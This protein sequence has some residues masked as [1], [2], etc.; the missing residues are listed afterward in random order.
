MAALNIKN[1]KGINMNT[2][3]ITVAAAMVATLAGCAAKQDIT[4][5][6]TNI[7]K[8][9]CIAEHKAVKAGVIDAMKKGFAK[10]DVETRVI[11]ANYVLKHQD[12]QTELPGADTTGCNAVVYYVANWRWDIALYMAYANIWIKDVET[13]EKIAQASYRTGGG[14]DKFIDAEE[15]IIELIDGMY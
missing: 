12:Y 9:V 15:K 5:F 14:L 2:L 8:T 7:P 11:P 13:N 6:E 4:R 3:K 1:K 10:H